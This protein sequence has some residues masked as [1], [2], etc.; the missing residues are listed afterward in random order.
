MKIAFIEFS[1]IKLRCQ[2]IRYL[3]IID[4]IISIGDFLRR[5]YN[6]INVLE[7]EEICF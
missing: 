7:E 5:A 4:N 3:L 1:N 2:N 6:Y